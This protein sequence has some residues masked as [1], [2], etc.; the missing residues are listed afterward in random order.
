MKQPKYISEGVH[1]LCDIHNVSND[2]LN[3]IDYLELIMTKA[4]KLSNVTVLNIYKH[5]FEPAGVTTLFSLSESHLS[6]HT[7][8]DLESENNLGMGMLDFFTCGNSCSPDIGVN[9]LI[10]ELCSEE[11]IVSM[12]VFKRGLDC[13]IVEV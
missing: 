1:Y 9:Y 2:K 5:K 13:G 4:C 3:D 8:V 7:Y 10:D 11:S 12:K 6:I